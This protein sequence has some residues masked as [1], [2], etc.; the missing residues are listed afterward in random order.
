MDRVATF[1]SFIARSPRD[2]FPRYGLAM[3]FRSRGDLAAAWETFE[4]LLAEHPT[5]VPA[6]LMAGQT[7]L[8]LGRRDQAA[9]V[10]RDGIA[11]ATVGG[12]SHARG[13]L[14]SALAELAEP[15][16]AADR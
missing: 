10:Y 1:Q 2:P 13:E 11:K 14:E 12:D 16:D 7:L 15:G 6:Y 3:E 5:Y 8:G 4:T 9:E